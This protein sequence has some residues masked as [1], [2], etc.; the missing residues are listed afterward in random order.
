MDQAHILG[1]RKSHWRVRAERTLHKNS[2]R[3]LKRTVCFCL[4]KHDSLSC[5]CYSEIK[6]IWLV[7]QAAKPAD[8]SGHHHPSCH[9]RENNQN[10][11]DF[12][13]SWLGLCAQHQ[14]NVSPFHMMAYWDPLKVKKKKKR[15]TGTRTNYFKLR[16]V[17]LWLCLLTLVDAC[18]WRCLGDRWLCSLLYPT[19][20]SGKNNTKIESILLLKH[21][22]H[23]THSSW[24]DAGTERRISHNFFQSVQK[25]EPIKEMPKR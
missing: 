16:C 7:C 24:F 12:R 17:C 21:W 10:I 25:F 1:E 15:P 6:N 20:V 19:K 23:K 18:T 5:F 8:T 11:S 3:E 2:S 22:K 4:S 14:I 9:A 13:K